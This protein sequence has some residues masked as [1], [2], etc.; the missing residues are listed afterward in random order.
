MGGRG[1]ECDRPNEAGLEKFLWLQLKRFSSGPSINH[2]SELL[3]CTWGG[4]VDV[5]SNLLLDRRASPTNGNGRGENVMFGAIPLMEKK[6]IN[7]YRPR[8]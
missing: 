4:L 5:Q 8:I 7:R 3:A 6:I 2:I 1:C